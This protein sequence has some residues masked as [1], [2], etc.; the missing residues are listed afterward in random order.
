MFNKSP[1]KKRVALLRKSICRKVKQTMKKVLGKQ[2]NRNVA[3]A[4][5]NLPNEV[6]HRSIKT[7]LISFS[8]K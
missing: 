5:T 4:T 3:T 6:N 7:S 2:T 1:S 8:Y